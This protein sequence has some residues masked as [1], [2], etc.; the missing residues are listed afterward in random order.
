ME[1]I[2]Q[3]SQVV[4]R[5]SYKRVI[6]SFAI[7]VAL[8]SHINLA[9]ANFS[10]VTLSVASM[11]ASQK[12]TA[13]K[14][15]MLHKVQQLLEQTDGNLS[16]QHVGMLN[17]VV[18]MAEQNT[19]IL[20]D[21]DKE[22][23]NALKTITRSNTPEVKKAAIEELSALIGQQL[24]SAPVLFQQPRETTPSIQINDHSTTQQSVQ[25]NLA[26]LHKTLQAQ[27]GLITEQAN[28]ISTE[29][30]LATY[31]DLTV[32]EKLDH[33]LRANKK[34]DVDELK[35]LIVQGANIEKPNPR[36]LNRPLHIAAENGKL[37]A[38][39]ILLANGAERSV[40][41]SKGFTAAQVAKKTNF[42]S[43]SVF[44]DPTNS[45][46]MPREIKTDNPLVGSWQLLT[47]PKYELH[48]RADYSAYIKKNGSEAEGYWRT[49]AGNILYFFPHTKIDSGNSVDHQHYG[50]FRETTPYRFDND[51]LV[52][53][54]AG[55][56][57]VKKGDT[58]ESVIKHYTYIRIELNNDSMTRK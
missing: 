14:R 34:L 15:D 30:E 16:P 12:D 47:N 7:T 39:K 35:R 46:T 43:I 21:K 2:K 56:V 36:T 25:D 18:Q 9:N 33:I 17:M 19:D 4:K 27:A 49:G 26:T 5:Q 41:N 24:N 23:I 57:G 22:I 31:N 40:Y 1:R 54:P 20:D 51:N 52:L 53:A 6:V 10:S 58:F 42:K 45:E 50:Y 8:T 32:D 37:D 13:K 3:P 11:Q 38:V 29:H 55:G 28:A 48:L 44:L